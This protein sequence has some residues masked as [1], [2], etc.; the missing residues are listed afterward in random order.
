[1]KALNMAIFLGRI[2]MSKHLV[3]MILLKEL[4]YNLRGELR[5]VVI[6]D[7][8]MYPFTQQIGRLEVFDN[9]LLPCLRPGGFS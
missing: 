2:G 8:D 9:N 7:F 1:M 3:E 6:S 4:P 5:T